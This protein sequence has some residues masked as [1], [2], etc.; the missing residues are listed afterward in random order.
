MLSVPCLEF[1]IAR[2]VRPVFEV[3]R[4]IFHMTMGEAEKKVE[5][6]PTVDELAELGCYY[7]DLSLHSTIDEYCEP[8][9]SARA[10]Y[11]FV[12][13][14]DLRGRDFEEWFSQ[15]ACALSFQLNQNY[16]VMKRPTEWEPKPKG[17]DFALNLLA[18]LKLADYDSGIYKSTDP[19]RSRRAGGIGQWFSD[20]CV[21]LDYEEEH[22]TVSQFVV[23][24]REHIYGV[25]ALQM[26]VPHMERIVDG[27]D[28]FAPDSAPLSA[29]TVA[30]VCCDD[31]AAA[32]ADVDAW[33]VYDVVEEKKP[34][35][36]DLASPDL[37]TRDVCQA[38]K[39]F[40]DEVTARF[41]AATEREQKPDGKKSIGQVAT[42]FKSALYSLRTTLC[43]LVYIEEALRSDYPDTAAADQAEAGKEAAV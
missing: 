42:D 22:Y 32:R 14:G 24:M 28:G 23:D 37:T 12:Y 20:C 30:A 25:R 33:A 1:F 34:Q 17:Q 29:S 39:S 40:G 6:K 41:A 35:G 11:E 27:S 7:R 3:Y 21:K 31:M 26:R 5:R 15:R 36:V 13:T 38:L 43:N 2:R 19:E 4:K 10:Y 16:N 9:I 18:L 8:I